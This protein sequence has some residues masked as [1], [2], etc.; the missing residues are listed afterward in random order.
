MPGPVPRE[1]LPA[2]KGNEKNIINIIFCRLF[3]LARVAQI[4][5]GCASADPEPGRGGEVKAVR[6]FVFSA[7]S[8]VTLE[9]FL[10][11][12]WQNIYKLV[13]E[14]IPN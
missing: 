7:L 13:V 2:I 8:R 9:S 11:T 12:K 1:T 4:L 3:A 14:L 10:E 5:N 6:A